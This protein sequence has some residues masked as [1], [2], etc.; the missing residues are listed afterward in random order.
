MS[1]RIE[2]ILEVLD[3]VYGNYPDSRLPI[4]EIRLNAAKA[5]ARIRGVHWNTISDKFIRQ[6]TPDV[7]GTDAFDRLVE[8][9]LREGSAQLQS[10]LARHA[11]KYDLSLIGQFF[12][13]HPTPRPGR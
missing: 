1:V 2:Q 6:L 12:A 9:W 5:V 4:S 7:E 3:G 11:D 13:Q 8:S 10:V